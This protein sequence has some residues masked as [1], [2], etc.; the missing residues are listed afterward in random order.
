MRNLFTGMAITYFSPNAIF[1]TKPFSF[2]KNGKPFE[3]TRTG[4]PKRGG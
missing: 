1:Q 3:T 4:N 2:G